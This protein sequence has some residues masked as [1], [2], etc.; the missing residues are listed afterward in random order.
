MTET[1]TITTERVDDIPLL[2]THLTRMG[3]PS[4]LEQHFH[5]HGNWQGLSAGWVATIWLAHVLSQG[6]HRLNQVQPW[7]ETRLLTLQTCTAH[8][9]QPLDLTD[10]RLASV[11]RML[12]NDDNWTSFERALTRDTLRVYDLRP[13][14][15]RIDTTTSSGYWQVTEDGL[16]QLGHSKDHRPDLPQLKVLLATLDPLG[17]PL[18]ADVLS[19]E[20]ADDPLY[21]PAI[22]RVRGSLMQRGLLYVGDCK[23]S[24]LA[25]RAGVAHAHDYYLCPLSAVQAPPA[26]IAGSVAAIARGEYVLQMIEREQ[27]DGTPEH[28]ADGFEVQQRMQAEHDT[29][30][31]RWTERR[32]VVRSLQQARTAEVALRKRLARA[33]HD[34][35]E[36]TVRRRGKRRPRDLA[37]VEHAAA[38]ILA[39]QRVADVLR[40]RCQ[41]VVRERRVRAYRDR[42]A[43]V[44]Q[45]V[46]LSVTSEVDEAAL[47]EAIAQLGWRVYVTNQPAEDLSLTQAVLAYR[48]EYVVERSLGRLK[49]QPL[50]LRP[51]YL[52]REEHATGL[53]RLLSI[54]LR[55]LTLLE[56][57]ARR[58][59]AV[60]GTPVDGVSAGQTT[61]TTMRPTAERLLA[62]FREV[63]LTVVALP[64]RVVHHLTPLTLVQQ[65]LLALVD[66]T[67]EVYLRLGYDSAQPPE[68]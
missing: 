35:A 12:S 39:Q 48:E 30:L 37:S 53:V 67:P 18:A 49:G 27:A 40:V 46:T 47:D 9:V 21:L 31:V 34:L 51:M 29:W 58:R 24:S 23:M 64:G 43:P 36:L 41:E 15:V 8:P 38:A 50:S 32:L 57:V 28:L 4:L 2:L 56:F 61:R 11:L 33:Q 5:Q 26:V 13:S 44:Q 52:E 20:C 10:D 60:E 55:V 17:M 22:A 68:I 54:G 16:F 42:P 62:A 19:G 3:V 6:D 65:R 45:T 7:A 59:V 66:C 63:T 1:L 14:R 25:T